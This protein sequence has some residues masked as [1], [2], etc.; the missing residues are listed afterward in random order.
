MTAPTGQLSLSVSKAG[1]VYGVAGISMA[2]AVA[3]G[4]FG[5][6]A[7]EDV[8]TEERL[9]TWQTAV[10]YQFWNTLGI[11]VMGITSHLLEKKIR[12]PVYL[13]MAGIVLFSGSLYTLCLTDI[14]L[15]GA[16]TPFGGVA[17]IGGWI[18]YS[19]VV[20]RRET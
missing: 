19:V 5:A 11:F 16:V 4:A 15:F 20:V 2:I 17:F 1:T 13:L 10:S 6:H 8:L 18:W 7:L 3:L 12:G 9:Q 14:G